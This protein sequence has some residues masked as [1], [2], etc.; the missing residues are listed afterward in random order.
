MSEEKKLTDEE[1]KQAFFILRHG[2]S[3][4]LSEYIKAVLAIESEYDRQKAEIERLTREYERIA[5]N[6]QEYLEWV[7]GFLRTHT[8]MKDRGEDYK[9][10]DREWMC[11]TFWA[12][13]EGSLDYIIDLENQRRELQKQVDE[14]KAENGQL[15]TIGNG[16]ALERNNL[17]EELDELKKSGNGVLL[18]SLYKKQADDHKRGLSVQRAYWKKKLQQDVKD[19][20]KEILIDFNE[21]ING[22]Y[23][24]KLDTYSVHIPVHEVN[25]FLTNK[26][27]EYGV[28]V[29]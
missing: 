6:K 17:R 9:M 4:G 25:D 29:E 28:E 1:L 16:F 8:V 27:K 3:E 13:I 5:Y 11:N 7:D 21:W 20:A 19:T 26:A 15:V 22:Q 12:K 2:S 24:A 18:T 10:F 14:L 23:D